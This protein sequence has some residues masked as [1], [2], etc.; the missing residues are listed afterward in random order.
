MRVE[1][2]VKE[3]NTMSPARAR[4]RTAR[5]GD[6][7]N[8]HVATVPSPV[9]LNL[10][11]Q[12]C[13]PVMLT[14]SVHCKTIEKQTHDNLTLKDEILTSSLSRN[15]VFFGKLMRKRKSIEVL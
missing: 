14:P 10:S 4:T 2:P 1:S 15:E 11:S 8:N 6:E 13:G 12:K 5:S 9:V 7:G 3:H